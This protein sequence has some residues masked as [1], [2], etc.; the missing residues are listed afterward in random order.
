[1]LR[2]TYYLVNNCPYV[3]TDQLQ[4]LLIAMNL[5]GLVDDD[6]DDPNWILRCNN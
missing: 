3:S 4:C 5:L 6:Y 2:Y 1:M